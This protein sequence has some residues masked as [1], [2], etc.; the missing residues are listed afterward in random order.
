MP[1]SPETEREAEGRPPSRRPALVAAGLA[2]LAAGL[3][4]IASAL[5]SATARLIGPNRPVDAEAGD[6]TAFVANNSPSL[7]RNPRRPANLAVTNR[8]DKPGFSCALHVSFDGGTTWRR[9]PVPFPAG[10]EEPARCYAPDAAFGP[11]GTLY[12]SFVTLKGLGNVPNAAWLTTSADGGRALS[13]PIPVLGPLAF[14]VRLAADP[15][16][17]GR[18]Y[19]SWLQAEATA[20]LAFPAPGNPI[21]FRR[22]DDGGATWTD[23]VTVSSPARQRVLAPS[24]V[25]GPR[26]ALHVLYLD[27]GDDA[28]DYSGA[29]AGRGGEPYPGRWSLV[30]A[31]SSDGGSTWK[32]TLVDGAIVPTRRFVVFLPPFPSLAVDQ[33]NGEVYVGF[34]DGR[35]GDSD[36]WVWVSRDGGRT[37]ASPRRVNDTKRGDKTSQ[38][39]ARLS[40]APSG[41]LDVVYYDRRAD[42][43]N[44]RNEVSLQSSS[45]AGAS[46]TRRVRLT[47]RPFDSRIGFGSE[48]G[49]ADLGS[50]LALVSEERRAVAV[51]TDTR[52]GSQASSKQD[53]ATAA[54]W[55]SK[56][57]TLRGTLQGAAVGV[58]AGAVGIV[59]ALAVR[60]GRGRQ[61]APHKAEGA[62]AQETAA[63]D[64]TDSPPRQV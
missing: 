62:H 47:D 34:H 16:V 55:F 1:S 45:D 52:A 10:E 14:Q 42:P 5:P 48:K 40:V 56:G 32:E 4:T 15:R 37:F 41:R 6:P 29:H 54:V 21:L 22:S 53:L 33:R 18:L 64:S 57:S 9:T 26:G 58:A 39:L 30:L 23:P 13:A 50:R 20:T 3:F 7:A 8:I 31:R 49:L 12:V 59:L 35:L 63:K 28:L 2:A 60:R 36:V 38:Y 44:V 25:V 61:R 51:W 46:F 19:L 11:D 17:A 27:V 24:V 43:G